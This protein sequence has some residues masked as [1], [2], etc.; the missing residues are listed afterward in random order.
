MY[1]FLERLFQFFLPS[2]CLCCQSYLEEGEKRICLDCLS[3][4]RWIF[5]PF[6]TVCGAPFASTEVD[7]HPCSA[8]MTKR[9]YF[10]MARALGHYEGPIQKAIHRW[11]YEG[12]IDLSPLFGEWMAEKLPQY[13]DPKCF[14]LILPVPLHKQRLRERGFNQ[15]LLLA[16]E[17]SGR[18]GIP[19]RKNILQKIRST[20]P[21]IQLSGA[22]REKAVRKSFH[23][24]GGEELKG[25]TLLLV[26]DVYTTGATVNE[27]S[28]VLMEA[29][30]ARVDVFTL[31]HAVKIS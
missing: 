18:T 16:R 8:C 24:L 30:A 14:D 10:T 3:K 7:C 1:P 20:L 15:A 12:K 4:I 2:Q 31:T 25:K 13:W 5:P 17:L 21:Q 26:D 19:Y 29:G 6:C 23:L 11:K 22:E 28:K 9:K 27:C